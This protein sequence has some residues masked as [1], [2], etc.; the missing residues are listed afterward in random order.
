MKEETGKGGEAAGGRRRPE[1]EREEVG[2]TYKWNPKGG[3]FFLE[4]EL[5]EVK[6]AQSCPTLRPLGLYSPWHSLGWNA[7]A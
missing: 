4:T 2:R 1:V 7:K 5:S 3:V 6:V